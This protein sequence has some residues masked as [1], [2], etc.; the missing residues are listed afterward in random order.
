MLSDALQ[1]KAPLRR[2]FWVYGVGVS[3]GYSALGLFIDPL[4]VKSIVLYT[5]VGLAI[6]VVQCVIL[7]RCAPNSRSRLATSLT[8]VAVI[9]GLLTIPLFL[10][11]LYAYPAAMIP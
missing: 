6:G 7:W 8:R 11:L 5:V 2:A 10:Y 9:I 4:N 1:G 3:V